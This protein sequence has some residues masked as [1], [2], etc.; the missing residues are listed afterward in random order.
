M[1]TPQ[2]GRERRGDRV[3]K[4]G[5]VRAGA[6]QLQMRAKERLRVSKRGRMQIVE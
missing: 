3:H 5:V 1:Q 2:A 6:A 4:A